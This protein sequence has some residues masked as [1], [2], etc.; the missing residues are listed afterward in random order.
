[1]DSQNTSPRRKKEKTNTFVAGFKPDTSRSG[2]EHATTALHDM[3]STEALIPVKLQAVREQIHL[4]PSLP[5]LTHTRTL[6]RMKK[7]SR[8]SNFAEVHRHR[9]L[10]FPDENSGIPCHSR[11][12]KIIFELYMKIM[13]VHTKTWVNIAQVC[14]FP[15]SVWISVPHAESTEIRTSKSK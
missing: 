12:T 8:V 14:G 5:P 3:M 11:E 1:M 15:D 6:T 7:V 13:S 2:V 9:I 10:H 4:P